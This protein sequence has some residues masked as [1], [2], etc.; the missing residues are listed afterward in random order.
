[1]YWL[2]ENKLY[3]LYVDIDRTSSLNA[4]KVFLQKNNFD[5]FYITNN[6]DKLKQKINKSLLFF[7]NA[8]LLKTCAL[9]PYDPWPPSQGYQFCDW[10]GKNS[11]KILLDDKVI[12]P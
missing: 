11:R 9:R 7:C 6:I 5:E 1:M 12:S 3:N 10:L 2:K 4:C 8:T